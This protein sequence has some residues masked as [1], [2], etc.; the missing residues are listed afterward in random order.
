M[1]VLMQLEKKDLYQ[2]MR[3]PSAGAGCCSLQACLRVFSKKLELVV[4]LR[5][6]EDDGFVE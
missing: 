6:R 5:L 1:G 2:Y 4:T 3:F